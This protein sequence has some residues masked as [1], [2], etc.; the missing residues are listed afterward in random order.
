MVIRDAT[1]GGWVQPAVTTPNRAASYQDPVE[2]RIHALEDENDLLRLELRR[3]KERQQTELGPTL[4]FAADKNRVEVRNLPLAGMKVEELTAQFAPGV[5]LLKEFSLERILDDPTRLLQPAL[6]PLV[7]NPIRIERLA[8]SIPAK[9]ANEA[10]RLRGGEMLKKEGLSDLNIS[11]EPGGRV[12]ATGS[13]DKLIPVPFNITGKLELT[14]DKKIRFAP[15]KVRLLGIPMPRLVV[16]IANAMAGDSL[17]KLDIQS[18]GEALIIDPKSFLPK[19]VQLQ[20]TRI[21][22]Q[23]DQLVLEGGPP[24]PAPP[25]PPPKTLMA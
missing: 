25:A 17:K 15:E 9:V 18:D 11:F 2:E 14:R 21:A 19:N 13:V 24:P 3:L 12:R 23:G 1:Q 6:D 5:D 7:E 4:Q 16:S 22:T 8:M 10:A 20:L